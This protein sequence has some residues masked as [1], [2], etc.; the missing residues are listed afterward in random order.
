MDRKAAEAFSAD[1]RRDDPSLAA[2]LW[3]V[4]R[5]LEAGTPN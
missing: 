3:I 5:K 2:P 1:V 4:E